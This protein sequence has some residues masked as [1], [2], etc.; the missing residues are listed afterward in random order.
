MDIIKDQNVGT[1]SGLE[2]EMALAREEGPSL[3]ATPCP[4]PVPIL[5]PRKKKH[6]GRTD[7]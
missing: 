3:S 5:T 6:V 2:G 7:R 4:L 1:D